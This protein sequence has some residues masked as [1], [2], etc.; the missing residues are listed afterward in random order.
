LA[1]FRV[2]SM[3]KKRRGGAIENDK[4]ISERGSAYL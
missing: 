3:L 1:V 4:S 2:T